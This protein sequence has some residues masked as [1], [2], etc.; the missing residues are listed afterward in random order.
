MDTIKLLTGPNDLILDFFAGSGTTGHAV[1]ELNRRISGARRFI[2]IEQLN[3]HIEICFDR[4]RYALNGDPLQV[5]GKL[6]KV[7]EKDAGNSDF[8]YAKLAEDNASI[9]ELIQEASS[10]KAL[11]SIWEKIKESHFISYKVN[12]HDVDANIPE[13][14]ELELN[15]QKKLLASLLDKN[16]LYV[17]LSEIESSDHDLSEKDKILNSQFYGSS[18]DPV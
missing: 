7:L 5:F 8:V 10:S 17:N 2:L 9:L 1:L 11:L 3:E 12:P 6:P 15:D 4:L 14:K 18:L 13:F 16:Q